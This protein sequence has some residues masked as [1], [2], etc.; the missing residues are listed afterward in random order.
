MWIFKKYIRR[1][2]VWF[3][4]LCSSRNKKGQF[5]LGNTP[6]NKNLKGEKNGKRTN[7]EN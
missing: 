6:W 1:L 3:N 2:K 5:R 4:L 7:K